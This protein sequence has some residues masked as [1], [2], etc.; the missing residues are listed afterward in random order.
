M[1]K[2][3]SLI[4]CLFLALTNIANAY[5]WENVHSEGDLSLN[6][7]V[8]VVSNY[9]W[10][11][12]NLGGLSVQ[13]WAEL[14]V[15]GFNFG[16]W[17]TVGSGQHDCFKQFIPEIDLSISY[18]SPDEHFTL[19]LTHYHYFDGKFISYSYDIDNLS[20]SQ[21]ELEVNIF[22]TEEYP[23]EI[24][25][26]VMFGGGD[27]YS[28]NGVLVMENEK[29]AKK[30]Y[31]T[32]L[33]LRYT[34]EAG[35]VTIIPEIGISPNASMYTYYDIDNEDHA[36][37][38]LNNISCLVNYRFLESDFVSMYLTGNFYFNLFDVLYDQP[39]EYGKNFCASIGL[40]IEL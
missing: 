3:K 25:C 17:G 2:I 12:Q 31:S 22:F 32:Y 13:P 18:T 36:N 39:F 9:N 7:G 28:A 20:S 10:R 5:T 24:G 34:A 30:L 21:S 15:V 4:L 29:R 14:E 1:K 11:G 33:Y 40:G 8:E 26:A 23:F 37:F 27:C 6:A 16:V 19:G 38:A 35:P